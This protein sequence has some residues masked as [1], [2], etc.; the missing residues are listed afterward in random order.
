[1]GTPPD[2]QGKHPLT[3]YNG[4]TP[5]TPVFTHYTSARGRYAPHDMAMTNNNKIKRAA[6]MGI[7]KNYTIGMVGSI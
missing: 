3:P 6:K 2:L 7:K 1:M 5:G 4:L